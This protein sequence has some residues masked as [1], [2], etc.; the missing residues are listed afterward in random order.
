[1]A[2]GRSTILQVSAVTAIAAVVITG[3]I[4]ANG[5]DVAQ[6]P[7]NDS[8]VWALQQGD[9]NRYARV[10]T[11]LHEL[12]T[13]K[14]V[15]NPTGLVQSDS[16]ALLFMERNGRVVDID[17][18]RPQDFDD[19]S[20]DVVD[21]PTATD[22]VVASEQFV[23]YLSDSGRIT[24]ARMD[25]GADATT[26]TIDPYANENAQ[27]GAAIKSF[28]A[29]VIVIGVDDVLYAYSA[30]EARV[31]RYDLANGNPLGF[32][33]VDLSPNDPAAHLTAVGSTWVLLGGDGSTLWAAGHSAAS[34][35]LGADAV[36]Q[37]PGPSADVVF[38]ADSGG[39]SE[40]S[41]ADGSSTRVV[42]RGSIGVPAAPLA[43]DGVTYGAWLDDASD[44]GLLWSSSGDEIDLSFG[45]QELTVDPLPRLRSNGHHMILNDIESG[46]IW[47]VPDGVLVA[48]SQ[49][50]TILAATSDDSVEEDEEA[51]LV[52]DRK[53]PVAEN[54]SFGVRA[55]Q[56]VS[57]PVLLN[58]HDPNKDVLT[59]D[60]ASVVGL[61]PGFGVVS[62]TNN[63][64]DLV[65]QVNPGASG[66]ATLHYAATDGTQLDGLLSVPA[67]VSLTVINPSINSAPV[68]CGVPNC[69]REWPTVQVQPGLSASAE[70]L[71]GWVDPEGDPIYVASAEVVGP[72][73]TAASTPD[74]RVLFQ[75]PDSAL[76]GGRAEV[77][78]RVADTRGAFAERALAVEITATPSL[79]LEPFAVVA[80]AGELLTVDPSSYI[81]GVAGSYA[82]EAAATGEEDS[83]EI[84]IDSSERTFRFFAP[85][86]GSYL[87]SY[88]VHDDLSEVI[89]TIRVVVVPGENAQ[90]S[91]SPITVFVRAKADATVD[92]FTAVSNPADKVLLLSDATAVP[93]PGA[94]L[95]LDVVNHHL[96]RVKGA[97]S[98]GQAGVV[99]T[100]RYTVSDGTGNALATA[101]GEATVILLPVLTPRSPIALPDSVTV[102]AGSQVDIQVL[103]NDLSPDGNALLL[104]ANDLHFVSEEGLAF[105]SGSAVRL[106]APQTPGVY[107]IGYSIYPAGS[108]QTSSQAVVRVTVLAP[109]ENRSP[110]PHAL[111]GRV[112]AGSSVV[113]PFV[114]FGVDPDGDAVVLDQI[115]TQPA[116]GSAAIAATG[117]G[118]VYTS[119]PGFSGAVE[120]DYQVRDHFGAT[121]TAAVRVGVL[122]QQSDPS[123]VT[124]SDYV[125]VQVGASN[126]VTIRPAANDLDPAGKALTVT[127]VVPDAVK[128]TDEYGDLAALI[129]LDDDGVVTLTAGTVLGSYAF[130]YTVANATG[131]T[132][133]GLIVMKVVRE[134]IPDRPRVSDTYLTAEQRPLLDTG[135][136]V[137]AGKVSWNSGDIETLTLSLWGDHPGYRV[138]GWRISGELPDESTIIPFQLTGTNVLGE[139]AS[140]FGFLRIPGSEDVILSVKSGLVP[141][142]VDENESVSF[143]LK[144]LAAVPQGESL[145]VD[146]AAVATGGA[147]T[148]ASCAITSGTTV[149]YD[150][151]EGE[152][153]V[154]YCSI[155]ARLST[156]SRYTMLLI[157][158]TVTPEIPLPILHSAALT[159]S[160]AAPPRT[161]DLRTMVDWAGKEDDESL[162]FAIT[163]APDQFVVTQSG[164]VVT[165]RALDTATPGRENTVKVGLSSHP[166]VA[167]AALS[168]TVGPAPSEL[169]K[170]GTVT[171]TG[172]TQ[173]N[174]ATSCFITVVGVPG[175]VNPLPG[176]PLALVSVGDT[177]S[178]VGV[179]LEVADTTRVRASWTADAPGGKCTATFVVRDAQGRLSPED[180][181]GSVL[182][183]LAGFPKAPSALIQ[184]G[185]GDGLVR[186]T[187][188]P[189]QAALAYPPL[190]GFTIYDGTTVVSQC[191]AQGT[192]ADITGV[193]NG[194]KV[195][196]T[197]RSNNAVGESKTA[198][199]RLA[200]GYL[201][202]LVDGVTRA[203]VYEPSTTA[204]AGWVEVSIDSTDPTAQAFTVTGAAGPVPRTGATT[205][206]AVQQPVGVRTIT[207]TPISQFDIPSGAGPVA[208]N[209]VG[210]VTVAG[211]P[212]F[213]AAP[214]VSTVDDDSLLVSGV[215]IDSNFSGSPL[216]TVHIAYP[217]SGAAASCNADPTGGLVVS[218]PGVQS[219]STTISGLDANT[220]YNVVVC[221][222]N[223]FGVGVSQIGTGVPWLVPGAPVGYTYS[224]SDGSGN[225]NFIITPSGVAPLGFDARYDNYASGAATL[226][227]Q[228]PGITVRHCLS[229]FD[230]NYCGPAS[231]VDPVD[232]DRAFQY[233][234]GAIADPSCV[235]GDVLTPAVSGQFGP[236]APAV[237]VTE[238]DYDDG[239]G[240]GVTV[241]GAGQVVPS[242]ALAITRYTV[243]ITFTS[244]T[245]GATY[246]Y[247]EAVDL[248]GSPIACS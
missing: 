149:T 49:D 36:L 41:L 188:S 158:I 39:I 107:E 216:D 112:L 109:G 63:A 88:T 85:T 127:D 197:A 110:E 232:S 245:T 146:R 203:P 52:S 73:G 190:S 54:D 100:V 108:P 138:T 187:V 62:L 45:G 159:Q 227:G 204:S 26:L 176:T 8:G 129:D 153:W 60:P 134:S 80:T 156:Q 161:Y 239:S 220:I 121:G 241:V 22:V 7:L 115:L 44:S 69:M 152:P 206:V 3:A 237:S 140:T 246:T 126:H 19:Q 166:G 130:Y 226:Y 185:Y 195:S 61:P 192:C 89:S 178:C 10:N 68:W 133:T 208:A 30:A 124:Y 37:R 202:P 20:V 47:T 154:D 236:S 199:T 135:I 235:I 84:T 81:T 139:E 186:L 210:A 17:E 113:I 14:D 214:S 193:V 24:A 222:S 205:V 141:Q 144:E 16:T 90:L 238:F 25:E 48:S 201:P 215:S 175:E 183:D 217:A 240:S 145:I 181:L 114:A 6:T 55:G 101:H 123:P 120:F 164:S 91:T 103:E 93:A 137:V 50:W 53:P 173:A 171:S 59:I 57:L 143:D 207:V 224:V 167:T 83:T 233:D 42:D 223:G 76:S 38:V 33:E 105:V 117:D 104:D 191:S 9:G 15:S 243:S 64:Q 95:D 184:S 125:E 179:T 23:A 21:T 11:E 94:T 168:L 180:R 229:G 247:T 18:A 111:V 221:T 209:T 99:G 2:I 58:D 28:V 182:L 46:W 116:R 32:D 5:F 56:L 151:G 87:V 242:G 165:I 35:G 1:M 4:I 31:F 119:V 77:T 248:P 194:T 198:A 174:N 106:L 75:H 170:G 118:I 70:I 122:D 244:S 150:A 82:I 169:P 97:T 147:R 13:V 27:P 136:D 148:E 128:G 66:T 196:Y 67:V 102:R 132:N 86:A 228:A 160:P 189:G 231:V 74:G 200:W 79:D 131:D 172:C 157:P 78:V 12:D 177:P 34:A 98:S 40:F 163:Y 162:L 218:G 142:V 71:R 234:V 155:G 29:T 96:L 219:A 92:V 212:F 51:N 65:V 213:D 211:N 230:D 43:L 72:I 225:G